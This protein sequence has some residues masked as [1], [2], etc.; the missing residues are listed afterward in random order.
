MV[1]SI[2]LLRIGPSVRMYQRCCH[3]ADY[4]D[5]CQENLNLFKVRQKYRAFYLNSQHV[6]LLPVTLN[7]H[8]SVLF[9]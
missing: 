3:W 1:K 6:L 8:R 7:G 4:H 5:V 9:E 2:C